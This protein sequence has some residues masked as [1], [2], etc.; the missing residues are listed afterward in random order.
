MGWPGPGV[1]SG[2]VWSCPVELIEYELGGDLIVLH[3]EFFFTLASRPV[4]YKF[5]LFLFAVGII[6][7]DTKYS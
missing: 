1:W 6:P 3:P 2:L 4:S 5:M 7:D